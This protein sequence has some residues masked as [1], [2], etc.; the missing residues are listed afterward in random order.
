M[1]SSVMVAGK[2]FRFSPSHRSGNLGLTGIL[3]RFGGCRFILVLL[4]P[5]LAGGI[6]ALSQLGLMFR[7]ALCRF[8]EVNAINWAGRQ[9]APTPDALGGDDRVH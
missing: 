5:M 1:S 2:S 7:P 8:H 4:E 9:T 3:S 6:A